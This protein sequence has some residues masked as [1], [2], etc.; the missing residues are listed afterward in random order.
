MT[1]TSGQLLFDL[2]I[3]PSVSRSLGEAPAGTRQIDFLAGGF[4]GPALSGR[5]V[6]GVDRLTRGRDG[7]FRPDAIL[8]LETAEGETLELTYRGVADLTDEDFGR[9]MQG[10]CVDYYH[11]VLA[12]F[13]TACEELE[14]LNATM[15]LGA[16]RIY[17]AGEGVVGVEYRITRIE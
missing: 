4:T 2:K 11:R 3:E 12:Q 17:P 5:I 7:R 8:L 9:I 10:E 1:R 6:G 14:W 16:G 13:S 15:A